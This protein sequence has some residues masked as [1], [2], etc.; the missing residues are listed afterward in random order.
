MLFE[1]PNLKRPIS[2]DLVGMICIV[3]IIT[4]YVTYGACVI[5]GIVNGYDSGAQIT[6]LDLINGIAQIATALAFILA[7]VQF[8]KNR[9]QQRQAIIAKEAESQ[10]EKMITVISGMEVGENSDL[11]NLNKSLSLLSNLATNFD[12]LFKAM[13]E[14]IQKGIVRMQWQ[15]MYFN[16]LS[17]ALGDIDSV[18]ILKKEASIDEAA[19]EEAVSE[20]KRESEAENI[21]PV[22][23]NYVFTEK[24]F[25][26]PNIK[27]AYSLTGKIDSLDMFVSHYLNDHNLNDLLYGLLSRI[28]IRVRAPILAVSGPSD[29][30]L[31]KSA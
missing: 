8:R 16:Y 17:H 4:A 14:D 24:L 2:L 6:F 15:D 26:H 1:K 31:E 28:D 10:L 5:Y 21:L 13:N 12:E 3:V 22:F 20:A 19:L 27:E 25:N 23:K 29:W 11:K 30:A 7:F 18:A 9:I